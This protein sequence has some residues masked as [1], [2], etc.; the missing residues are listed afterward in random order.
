MEDPIV[1]EVRKYREKHAARFDY[2]IRAIAAD[3][4]SRQG[5]DGAPVVSLPPKR[6]GAKRSPS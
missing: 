5:K 2:D 1:A 6:I 4:K 3:F